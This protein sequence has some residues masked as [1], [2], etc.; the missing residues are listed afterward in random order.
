[1]MSFGKSRHKSKRSPVPAIQLGNLDKVVANILLVV[2]SAWALRENGGYQQDRAV[3]A[4]TFSTCLI[5]AVAG[6]V[7]YG[8]PQYGESLRSIYQNTAYFCLTIAPS[9][10][11]A[12][13]SLM[14]HTAQEYAAFLVL[15]TFG[16]IACHYLLMMCRNVKSPEV[17]GSDLA[18]I[19]LIIFLSL[20]L[21]FVLSYLKLNYYGITS[22]LVFSYFFFYPRVAGTICNMPTIN[23]FLIQLAF[24][25]FNAMRS[26]RD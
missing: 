21:I 24:F 17:E 9:F 11:A 3:A 13:L 4:V 20:G 6:V 8:N 5:H 14:Y 10:Y 15:F 25:N 18:L 16:T 23:L 2:C 1:M 7:R 12:Q 22:G 26:L 19:R